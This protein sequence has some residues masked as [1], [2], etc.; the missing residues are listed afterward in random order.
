MLGGAPAADSYSRIFFPPTLND[1]NDVTS[2]RRVSLSPVKSVTL[3]LSTVV[4]EQATLLALRSSFVLVAAPRAAATGAAPTVSLTYWDTRFGA[5]IARSDLSVPSAVATTIDTLSISACLPNR[6]TAIVTLAPSQRSSSPSGPA[7]SRMALFCLPLSPP[8]PS[9]SVLAAI[10]GRQRLTS[11][12]V[13]AAAESTLNESSSSSSIVARAKRAEPI[14]SSSSSSSVDAGRVAR[15]SILERLDEVLAPLKQQQRDANGPTAS[16]VERAIDEAHVA[17]DEFVRSE[18][19]RTWTVEEPTVV[20]RRKEVAQRTVDE[21]KAR[22]TTTGRLAVLGGPDTTTDLEDHGRWKR[23]KRVVERAIVDAGSSVELE[24]GEQDDDEASWRSVV[25]QD[26]GELDGVVDARD[27]E[28]YATERGRVEAEI[29]RLRREANEPIKE[30][31][32]PEVC[33]FSLSLLR[34]QILFP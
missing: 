31:D 3:S 2:R 20:K 30:A 23:V 25:V 13:N 27:R 33:V 28:R 14:S 18:R 17:W 24:G 32:R 19:H 16:V 7:G 34:F 5:V 8:L 6:N 10:V 11:E 29:K 12:Y 1:D 15:A 4:P 26:G 22:W 21:I 9:A